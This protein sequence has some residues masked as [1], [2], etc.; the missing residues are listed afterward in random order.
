MRALNIKQ[1]FIRNHLLF[2]SILILSQLVLLEDLSA[3]RKR[4]IGEETH[5]VSVANVRGHA[6]VAGEDNAS[7][8]T[9]SI[10]S[11]TRFVRALDEHNITDIITTVTVD[12]DVVF[13]L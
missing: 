13:T 12:Q 2:P 11:V 9:T 5:V 3:G 6:I 8:V 1:R 7:T 10:G 4:L